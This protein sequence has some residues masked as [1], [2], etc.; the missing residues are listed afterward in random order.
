ME[1]LK[2]SCL[3]WV[4]GYVVLALLLATLVYIRFP[5]VQVALGSGF[6]AAILVG[7]TI[8]YLLGIRVRRAEGRLI[9]KGIREGRPEDGQKVAV[10][11]RIS[12][13]FETVEA[14]MTGRPCVAY[15]YKA[16]A[17]NNQ[18]YAAYEGFAL[19]PLSIDGPRGSIRLLATPELAFDA[20]TPTRIEQYDK[21]R[22]YISRTQFTI[23]QGVNIK[24]RLAHLKTILADDDGRIRYDV[25]HEPAPDV[26]AMRLQEKILAP[27]EHVVAIGR[28]SAS[29]NA[30]VPDAS[31][32][33]HAV[34]IRKGEPGALASSTGRDLVDML[35]G[36]GCL[37]PVLIAAII[38][39][40]SLPLDGIEQMFPKKDP[41]WT[42][43]RVDRW[44]RKTVRPKLGSKFQESGE[45]AIVLESG[46]ARG[47]LT[48]DGTTTSLTRA[49]ATRDGDAIEVSLT[50]DDASSGVIVRLRDKQIESLRLIGGGT[51]DAAYAE[52][53]T[54]AYDDDSINGRF[55]A[56]SPGKGPH[57]RAMFQTAFTERSGGP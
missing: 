12:S 24:A 50:S 41:S 9:R 27:G 19:V 44:L 54:L 26:N 18:Q 39:L 16:L 15:E 6:A 5:R 42:E 46:E 56:L 57:M 2:R 22:D 10:V 51:I 30:L 38:G 37:L 11:G 55:L 31:A 47:K 36:C 25:R 35:M 40:A 20:E 3:R 48:V 34:K 7:M 53:E 45:Y 21:F 23:E 8:A 1:S 14:P 17:G 13:S 4:I 49:S 32:I 29:R 52:V 33:L 43:V 28:Y